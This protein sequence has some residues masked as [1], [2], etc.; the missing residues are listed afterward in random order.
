VRLCANL[1]GFDLAY[2]LTI[3][4]AAQLVA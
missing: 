3:L 2:R 1:L 4:G